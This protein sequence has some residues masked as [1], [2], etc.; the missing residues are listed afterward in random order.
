MG[1]KKFYYVKSLIF[2]HVLNFW[3][4]D[5]LKP[6]VL[7]FSLSAIKAFDVIICFR[8]RLYVLCAYFLKKKGVMCLL[9]HL[10]IKMSVNQYSRPV[11]VHSEYLDKYYLLDRFLYKIMKAF[12]SDWLKLNFKDICPGNC[13]EIHFLNHE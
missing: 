12:F 4:F 1:I 7:N 9:G 3:Q 5:M 11:R 13:Q 6:F 10:L 2:S 8:Q